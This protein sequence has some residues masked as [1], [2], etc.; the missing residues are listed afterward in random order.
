[1]CCSGR[2]PGVSDLSSV[3]PS[4]FALSPVGWDAIHH[5][6]FGCWSC[7]V[8]DRVSM[9]ECTQWAAPSWRLRLHLCSPW[10]LL[11]LW[12]LF[13]SSHL[14]TSW[15]VHLGIIPWNIPVMPPWGPH[16]LA[17]LVTSWWGPRN[18]WVLSSHMQDLRNHRS[19]LRKCATL[20]VRLQCP[21]L[22]WAHTVRRSS[23]LPHS[24][25]S[26]RFFVFSSFSA[27]TRYF[28]FLMTQPPQSQRSGGIRSIIPSFFRDLLLVS[29]VFMLTPLE[30][31]QLPFCIH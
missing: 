29:P 16:Q 7:C 6:V 30:R 5:P 3:V 12:G 27:L 14:L 23:R 2:G 21:P 1:M 15:E 20:S 10:G 8:L 24:K 25:L 9:H 11:V 13:Y 26:I 19:S 28:I 22:T 4:C 18:L 31:R 17:C